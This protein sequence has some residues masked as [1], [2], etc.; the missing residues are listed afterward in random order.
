MRINV[1]EPRA[2]ERF[3]EGMREVAAAAA[4]HQDP[5]LYHS[6]V[7]IGRAAL[8]QG[9]ELVPSSGLFL[10]CPVCEVLPG[11]RCVNAPRHPLQDNILHAERTE[12]A[13]KALRGEVPFPHPLR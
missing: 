3:W 9:V 12:L 5:G 8:A 2:A 7:K 10:E 11:Q 1:E 13:E 6:I 4:R